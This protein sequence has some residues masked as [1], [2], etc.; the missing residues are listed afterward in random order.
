MD[1]LWL[2]FSFLGSIS[3]V[4]AHLYLYNFL[5]VTTDVPVIA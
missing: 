1:L 5:I 3:F 2:S 4:I